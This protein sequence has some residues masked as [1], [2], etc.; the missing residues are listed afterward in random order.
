VLS[1]VIGGSGD[2]PR[3]RR[4]AMLANAMIDS[5]QLG[6]A[7]PVA[8]IV[9]YLRD[10][11][12]DLRWRATFVLGRLMVP[13]AGTGVLQALRDQVPTVREAAARSLT[14]RFA[15]STGLTHRQVL[16]EL[17][18]ALDD[19]QAGVRINALLSA[20]SFRD[21][22]IAERAAALLKDSDRMVRVAA[23]SALA[24]IGGSL[25]IKALSDALA[26][27]DAPWPV[28]RN[29]LIGLATLDTAGFT[30]RAAPWLSS[31]SVFDRIAGLEALGTYRGGSANDFESQLRHPD[32]RVRAAAIDA[33]RQSSPTEPGL[34]AAASSA[35][36]DT[37]TI[38]RIAAL[39]VMTRSP[40]DEGLGHVAK[41]WANGSDDLKES[42]LGILIRWSRT[43]PALLTKL[44]G[45]EFRAILQRPASHALYA[46]AVRGWPALA[47]RWGPPLPIETGRT[48]ADYR[49][50]AR[51]FALA[52]VNPRIKLETEERGTIEVELLAREAPLTVA[53]MLRLV[54][55]RYFDNS[56]WHRVVPNFVI[57]DGDPSG[58]GSGGPGWSIRDEINRRRY[59]QPMLGMAL[60][61]PDTGGSQWFINLSP[62]PHL[63]GIYTIFGRVVGSYSPVRRVL[64]GDVI[65]SIRR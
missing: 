27:K 39:N 9:P 65:R 49:E 29:A 40:S 43:D 42:A 38:V 6:A 56:R 45:A 53:N 18:R 3:Q 19:E 59:L 62:Q 32:P 2:L 36:R 25:A 4:S 44:N 52:T 24:G 47:Q 15:D 10:T 50:I 33:W 31:S 12:A 63:D 54:D 13:N 7:A 41:A 16:A 46:Q 60:S 17:E 35:A 20:A 58:T 23:A 11:T 1:D 14:R 22:M 64:Q 5:W 61:G 8:V 28:R 51:L 21:S 26:D 30:G 55:R 48:I 57:Q 34:M 37:A